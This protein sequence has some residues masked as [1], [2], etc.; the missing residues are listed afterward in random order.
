MN[1]MAKLCPSSELADFR[2]Q[3]F[4]CLVFVKDISRQRW[5]EILGKN[6][7]RQ[8][9]QTDFNKIPFN[10][11]REYL[12][13]EVLIA[14]NDER[15]PRKTLD[16]ELYNIKL[17]NWG[18][19]AKLQRCNKTLGDLLLNTAEIIPNTRMELLRTLKLIFTKSAF[20]YYQ[21]QFK[22]ILR[23]VVRYSFLLL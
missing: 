16:I 21:G 17:H 7:A 4:R 10:A 19:Y 20:Q 5:D 13:T 11:N 15:C 12:I 2:R 9:L 23:T 3:C 22:V 6:H 18:E 1:E 14:A 8:Y